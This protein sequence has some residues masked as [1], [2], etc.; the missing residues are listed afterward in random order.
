MKL[1]TILYSTLCCILVAACGE[2]Q[3]S[4][5]VAEACGHKLL[6]SDLEGVVAEGLSKEDSTTIADNYINQWI[7]QTVVMEQAQSEITKSFEKEL[8]N[9]R[10]SLLTYEYE[11]LVIDRTLDTVVSNKELSDYYNTHQDNFTLRTNILKAIYVKFDKDAPPI[12]TV[13]RMMAATEISDKEMDYIQKAAMQ[14]GRDYN[15]DGDT[16]IPFFRFQTMVP[17]TTYNEELYLKNNRNIVIED[18][19]S[20]YIA[21]ILE[22]RLSE[23]LSPLS[24]ETER[25]KNIILNQRRIEIIKNMQRD[26]LS[27]AEQEGKIKKYKW[28]L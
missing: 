20:V 23:E 5:V 17:I 27:K 21:K 15:F 3:E 6:R 24:Y 2:R 12:K 28:T 18:S 8:E 13:T 10:A 11:Q 9:Y 16:W 14:Y 19:S 22:Y 25:I 4:D 26:L 7:Q 1:K